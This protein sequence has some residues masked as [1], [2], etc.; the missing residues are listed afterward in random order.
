[1]P[2]F[3]VTHVSDTRQFKRWDA[4]QDSGHASVPVCAPAVVRSQPAEY[5]SLQSR[6]WHRFGPPERNEDYE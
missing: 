2:K 1:M 4:K 3:E 6:Q 5:A